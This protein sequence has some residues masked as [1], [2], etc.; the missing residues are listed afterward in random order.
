MMKNI[1]MRDEHVVQKHHVPLVAEEEKVID[2][3][4]FT[5]NSSY[6]RSENDCFMYSF[7]DRMKDG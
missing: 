7:M 5:A 3:N 6:H 1:I 4:H 2:P